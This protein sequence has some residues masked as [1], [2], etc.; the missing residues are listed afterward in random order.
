[1]LH[2]GGEAPSARTDNLGYVMFVDVTGWA[3]GI[4]EKNA[5]LIEQAGHHG[6]RKLVQLY[7]SRVME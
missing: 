5:I 3:S 7:L 6:L 1:M 4:E 2:E